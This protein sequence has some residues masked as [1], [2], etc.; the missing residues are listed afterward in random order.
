VSLLRSVYN[1]AA[2]TALTGFWSAV[3]ILVVL[4]DRRRIPAIGMAW[5]RSVLRATGVA[6]ELRGTVEAAE[7]PFL[8]MANHTSHFDTL[9]LYA[10]LPLPVRFVA[11]REL[12]WIPLFG[13]PLL[14]LGAA[15][16]IDRKDRARAIAS[17]ARAQKVID[18]GQ[19]VL[20]FPE[21]TRTPPGVLGPLKKGPFHLAVEA[22][23]PILPVGIR[24]TGRVLARGDWRVHPGQVELHVG[25][26]IPT[27]AVEATDS[28]RAALA[29]KVA[30]ALRTLSGLDTHGERT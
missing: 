21:G 19:S 2:L 23:V 14:T 27:A 12:Q 29:E 7:G 8:V 24:G 4:V 16:V 6:A 10:T 20:F 13:F 25:A 30:T 17:I 15:I 9:A 11:K 1:A 18:G 3:A 22:R 28:G 26:P 5:S